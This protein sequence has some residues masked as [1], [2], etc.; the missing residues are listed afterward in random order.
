MLLE[1]LQLS[2][3][4]NEGFV[5]LFRT[6]DDLFEDHRADL[7]SADAYDR[8]SHHLDCGRGYAALCDQVFE[9]PRHLDAELF[10]DKVNAFSRGESFFLDLAK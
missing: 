8:T 6:F 9:C 3:Y 7:D 5:E 1:F 10:S 2:I 4:I